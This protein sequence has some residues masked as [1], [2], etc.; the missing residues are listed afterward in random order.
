[1]RRPLVLTG[2]IGQE[3]VGDVLKYIN[4]LGDSN[5]KIFVQLCTEGG[6]LDCA[7]GIYDMLRH[8][9]NEV[10]IICIGSCS[11]AGTLIICAADEVVSLPHTQFLIH[12]GYEVN[13][14][15]DVKKQN[16]KMTKKYVHALSKKLTVTKGTITK[17]LSREKYFNPLEAKSVGLITHIRDIE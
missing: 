15:G 4:S 3:M 7:F 1:M 10:S 17:W 2:E 8:I 13:D 12:Y 14:S 5:E 6:D 9:D 11:S 16:D